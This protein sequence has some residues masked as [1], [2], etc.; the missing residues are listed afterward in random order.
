MLEIAHP[1]IWNQSFFKVMLSLQSLETDHLTLQ[2]MKKMIKSI[3]TSGLCK[4]PSNNP[5]GKVLPISKGLL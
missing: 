2:K 1:V 3:H 4:S 5:L